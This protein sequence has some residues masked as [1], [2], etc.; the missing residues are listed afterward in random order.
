M[1]DETSTPARVRWAR[2]R[3]QIIGQLLAAPP[4]SGELAARIAELAARPWR[5]PTTGEVIRFS[6]KAIERWFYAARGKDEPIRA[7]ERKVPEHAGSHPSVSDAVAAEIARLRRDHPRWSYRLVHDNLLVLARENPALGKLPGYASVCRYMKHHGLGKRRRLRR[8]EL[9]PDFVPRERRSFEV[10]H[11]HALWHFD[12]HEAR[13]SVVLPSGERQSARPAR[14]PRRSLPALLPRAVVPRSRK[15]PSRSSTGCARRSRNAACRARCSATTAPPCSP[16]KPS[17]GLERL[18][19]LQHPT[20]PQSPE[21]NGKQESFWTQVEGRLMAMLEGEPELTLELLNRATQAWV[22]QE[23]HR[24][25]HSE[26]GQTPL[27]RCLAGPSVVRPCPSSDALRRAF[28]MEVRSKQRL[29]DGTIT[30]EGVRYE[31]PAAYRTLVW[32]SVRVARWD[33]SSVDLV[34]PR[35]GAHL[36][37]LLPLDRQKNAD[38]RR[39][40]LPRH[41]GNVARRRPRG[42]PA[43]RRHR[44]A[45]APA[46][47]GLRR[48]RPSARLPAQR[49]ARHRARSRGVRIMNPKLQSLYGLKFNPFRPDVPVDAL[50]ATP[51]V[52]AF[53]RRVELGIAD[54][55][56]VMITGDPGTGKSVVLRLLAQRLQALRDVMV[57]TIEHPQSRTMDFYREL[58]DLFAVPLGAHNR[59]GGFKALRSRW[60]EHIASTLTRPVLIIDEAQEALTAV[61][62][63][64]RVLASKEL[65]STPAPLRRLCRRRSPR[66]ALAH[67]RSLAARQPHPPPPR[68][69]LRLPRRA[70][71]LPRPSARRRRQSDAHDHR[72]QGH[73][74]RSRRRQLPRPHESLRRAAHHRRRSR[75]APPR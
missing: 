63:E 4:E 38:R 35:S 24:R 70:A 48:H 34:D 2:L 17:E 41:D 39:R 56:Y 7:L 62:N 51:A 59:W 54:G 36:A 28:R 58:G 71:R 18:S 42:V 45:L 10:S 23:Y 60:A 73:P 55:G 22:E 65:D 72:A 13:R 37:T 43:T 12:F 47:G 3:F 25:V 29:S 57:G 33:L 64:L 74:R 27:D 32:V 19:I 9:E 46:D 26:T 52:D 61:F 53:L 15:T 21:Q 31:L 6:A 40:A 75:A 20:L 67:R 16:P 49:P 11:V 5:H 44:P 30:V 68:P 8:H 69:R 14:H 50:F 66:R 1:S